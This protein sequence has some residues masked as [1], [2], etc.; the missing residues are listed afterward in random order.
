MPTVFNYVLGRPATLQTIEEYEL[1]APAEEV[2]AEE[3]PA[4]GNSSILGDAPAS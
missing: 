4:E 1:E 2:V 3:A